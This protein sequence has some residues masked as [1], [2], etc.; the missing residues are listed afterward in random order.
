MLFDIVSRKENANDLIRSFAYYFTF[1]QGQRNNDVAN[2]T[3]SVY[4]AV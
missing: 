1:S 4:D 3:V 2:I